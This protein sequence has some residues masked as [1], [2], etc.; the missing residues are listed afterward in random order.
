[1]AGE[2]GESRAK[3]IIVAGPGGTKGIMS[4]DLECFGRLYKSQMLLITINSDQ[5]GVCIFSS[6]VFSKFSKDNQKLQPGVYHIRL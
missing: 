3:V 2:D 6:A 5:C 1:M 4:P